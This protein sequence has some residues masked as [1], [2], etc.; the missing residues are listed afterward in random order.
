[1]VLEWI[2]E[3]CAT[4]G[5]I[6]RNQRTLAQFRFGVGS[7][8]SRSMIDTRRRLRPIPA[9]RKG[10][11]LQWLRLTARPMERAGGLIHRV[12]NWPADAPDFR[13]ASVGIGPL[14]R[15]PPAHIPWH[16]PKLDRPVVAP[17]IGN[18]SGCGAGSRCDHARNL[19]G[20]SACVDRGQAGLEPIERIDRPRQ[21]ADLID[22]ISH[23]GAIQHIARAGEM[24]R[25]SRATR[26]VTE[27]GI[28]I[29]DVAAIAARAG[30]KC[31]RTCHHHGPEGPSA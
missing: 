25:K 21:R 9:D 17:R 28:S 1:M 6:D 26:L 24:H 16:E 11:S 31:K 27:I 30:R 12:W 22:A 19:A 10:D 5:I 7:R 8:S 2:I 20:R 15:I 14:P 23:R 13:D 29:N 4:I 3:T 18:R